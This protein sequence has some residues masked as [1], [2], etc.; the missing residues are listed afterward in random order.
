MT[1]ESIILIKIG[2][3]TLGSEDTSFRDIARLQQEGMR[4]VVVHGGGPAITSWMAKLGI[5][6]EFVNGLRVTDEP[7]LEVVTAVLAGMINKRLV[8][9][10][11]AAGANAVGLCGADGRLFRGTVTEPELGYVAGRIS[12]DPAPLK[13]LLDGGYVPVIAPIAVDMAHG[14]HLLNVNADTAAGATAA[15]LKASHLVFLTDVDGIL[16]SSG[17]LLQRVPVDTAE[18]LIGSGIVK[19]GMIPKL[20]ACIDACRAGITAHIVNGTSPRA[21]LHC[22]DGTVTGTTVA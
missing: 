22:L 13:T 17:R 4:P 18:G 10:I 9:Q 12:V 7:S 14:H 1:D 11:T 5:R 21:L 8:A 15:A 20:Q 16:D 3:S 2:G 6:A 19:G